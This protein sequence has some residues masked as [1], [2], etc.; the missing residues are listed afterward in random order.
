MWTSHVAK[1]VHNNTADR[2]HTLNCPDAGDSSFD[3]SFK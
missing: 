1:L 3:E 2:K